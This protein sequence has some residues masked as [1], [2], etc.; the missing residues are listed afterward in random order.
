MK[1]LIVYYSF[2]GNTKIA[3]LTLYEYLKSRG[4]VEMVQLQWLDESRNFFIQSARALWHVRGNIQGVELNLSGY[5]LVCFG[6]PVWAF[7]PAP[8]MNTYLDNSQGLEGKQAVLFTTYGSGTGNTRCLDY[9][10]NIL[11]TKG[12]V[13][14]KRFSVKQVG[15]KDRVMVRAIIEKALL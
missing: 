14:F 10:Q 3:A 5:D 6:T 7:G 12:V 4:Q 1:I 9:M 8:A 2:S 15:L 11:A 13:S